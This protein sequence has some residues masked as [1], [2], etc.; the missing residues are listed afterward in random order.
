MK[1]NPSLIGR[2]RYPHSPAWLTYEPEILYWW[3][4]LRDDLVYPIPINP[5]DSQLLHAEKEALEWWY[6]MREI[7]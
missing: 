2:S 6:H 7:L 1:P 3:L 4:L 5:R